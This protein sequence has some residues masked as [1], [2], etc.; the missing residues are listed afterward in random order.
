MPQHRARTHVLHPG[1]VVV[2]ARGET[3]E[4]LLGS[5]VA[6]ILTD[7]RRSVA[8]MCHVVHTGSAGAQS[9][10]RDT[11]HGEVALAAMRTQLRAI[12]IDAQRCEAYLAGG[13]NMFPDLFRADHVGAQNARWALD[14]VARLGLPLL[15]Q[16]LGGNSYR[17]L[18][19]T[20]GPEAPAIRAVEVTETES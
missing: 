20:V 10:A 12:G 6:L 9:G 13:G 8:A 15:A 19:W 18:R 4:T 1:D 14:A 3:L 2:A 17:R 5:C 11:T 7:A 16:D